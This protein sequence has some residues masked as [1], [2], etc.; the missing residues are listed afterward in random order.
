[1]TFSAALWG[2]DAQTLAVL[3]GTDKPRDTEGNGRDGANYRIISRP[4][5]SERT[6]PPW[7]LDDEQ[8]RAVIVY[9]ATKRIFRNK[10]VP[11]DF[12]PT[13]EN[14]VKGTGSDWLVMVSA[15]CYRSFRLHWHTR[16]TAVS[17]A[18]TERSVMTIIQKLRRAAE[19]LG[20]DNGARGNGRKKNGKDEE[21]L[22]L[23]AAGKSIGQIRKEL[24]PCL[25]R[26]RLVLKLA[27]VWYKRSGRMTATP[28]QIVEVWNANPDWSPSLIAEHLGINQCTVRYHLKRLGHYNCRRGNYA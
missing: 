27:G 17:L 23:W 20:F 5:R 13:F 12:K 22:A 9:V 26:I 8:Q 24:G 3:Y 18:L 4:G 11:P 28:K 21:I 25:A 2:F 19:L 6:V 16:D 15:I 7:A 10:T 1:M 14:L